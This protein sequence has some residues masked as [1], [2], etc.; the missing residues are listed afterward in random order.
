MPIYGYL[1]QMA[2]FVS[3]M[4]FTAYN[5]NI[6]IVGIVCWAMPEMVGGVGVGWR[7]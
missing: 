1:R 7:A 2:F 4:Y 5:C 6:I 3:M